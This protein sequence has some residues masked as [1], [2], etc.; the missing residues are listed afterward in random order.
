MPIYNGG[1]FRRQTTVAQI[2]ERVVADQLADLRL[3]LVATLEQTYQTY[4]NSLTLLNLEVQN[5]QIATQ[6]IDIA[7][8]RYRVGNSTA[9]EFR[10]VQRNAVQ[11]QTRL[12]DASFNAKAAE[13]EL[14]R[15]SSTITK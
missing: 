7:Y 12:F 1:N 14:L 2:N 4:R 15:L 3:Q 11:A 9:V 13:I 10:D 6:N 8:E 5:Y